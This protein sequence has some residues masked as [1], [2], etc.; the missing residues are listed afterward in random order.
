MFAQMVFV[1]LLM[2]AII[3]MIFC[4]TMIQKI[5]IFMLLEIWEQYKVGFIEMMKHFQKIVLVE[6]LI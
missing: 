2:R 6:L 3:H 1:N 4:M 5:L